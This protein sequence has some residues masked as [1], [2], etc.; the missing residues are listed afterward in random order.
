[1]LHMPRRRRA[2]AEA[3]GRGSIQAARLAGICWWHVG[4]VDGWSRAHDACRP[5][6]KPGLESSSTGP[7]SKPASAIATPSDTLQSAPGGHGSKR[8]QL[9]ARPGL[10]TRESRAP[11]RASQRVRRTRQT[12]HASTS[13]RLAVETGLFQ[14]GEE[15]ARISTEREAPCRNKLHARGLVSLAVASHRPPWPN[16]TTLLPGGAARAMFDICGSWLVVERR[17]LTKGSGSVVDICA[18]L[19]SVVSGDR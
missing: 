14:V 16:K 10:L 1:M 6:T 4:G 9:L 11:G 13:I 7:Q 2:A 19:L 17:M 12:R 5:L 3:N 15:A 8:I 18:L